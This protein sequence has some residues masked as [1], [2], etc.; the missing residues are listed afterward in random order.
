MGQPTVLSLGYNVRKMSRAPSPG[1]YLLRINLKNGADVR[2]FCEVRVKGND[3]YILQPRKGK[4]V[5]ISY[6]ESGQQHLTI[7]SGVPLLPPMQPDPIEA[8]LTEEKPWSNSFENFADLLPYKRENANDVFEIDLVPLQSDPKTIPFAQVSV[9]RAFDSHGWT[10]DEV[11]QLTIKQQVFPLPNN[12]SD[13]Q[14][15]VR[16]LRLQASA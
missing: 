16:I 7:G 4:S 12:D 1:E 13:L 9:G 3:V 2:R 8:I 15:C 6:H 11:D 5:K 10:M 14:F